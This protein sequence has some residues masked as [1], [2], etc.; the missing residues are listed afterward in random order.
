MNFGAGT[1][2]TVGKL[3]G[4]DYCM[5]TGIGY[6]CVKLG[7]LIVGAIVALNSLR[8]IFDWKTGEKIAGL[9]D[10][11]K[12]NFLSTYEELFKSSAE[13]D[14]RFVENA[15]IA[16][17]FT[18]VEFDKTKLC[19]IANMAPNGYARSIRPVHTSAD[20]GTIYAVSI[21][22]IKAD[23]DVVGILAL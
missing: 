17:V 5:K 22:N 16:V 7:N 14:N 1:G 21:G 19:K 13:V 20:G 6:Y 3:L 12:E 11:N 8:D 23:I 18:N 4:M 9:L 10:E 2:A 15:T